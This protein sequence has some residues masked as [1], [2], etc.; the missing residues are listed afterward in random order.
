MMDGLAQRLD[1]TLR[2]LSW[3][4]QRQ[5]RMRGFSRPD[6][7]ADPSQGQGRILAMLKLRDGVSTKDL[8]YLLGIRT[9]SLNEALAK[10]EKAGL[11]R[12]EASQADRRV[13]LVKLTKKGRNAEQ[14]EV[15]SPDVY[16]CLTA[17]EQ[18]DLCAYL[19]RVIAALERELGPDS[20]EAFERMM[21]ARE[22][23]GMARFDRAGDRGGGGRGWPGG[24]LRRG[25]PGADPRR[26]R[27]GGDPRTG[28][29]PGGDPRAGG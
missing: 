17:Q 24:D 14:R 6:P 29:F 25:F 13:M 3:L 5:D 10:L 9:S 4:L 18:A 16:S 8:S 21:D 1:G 11:A 20:P 23:L 22:R 19:D 27:P 26:S 7:V 15:V 2:R 28:Y 12:R